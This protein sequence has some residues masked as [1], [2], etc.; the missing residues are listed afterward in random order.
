MKL[1]QDI[2]ACLWK[3]DTHTYLLPHPFLRPYIAHYTICHSHYMK[4]EQLHLVPDISGCIVMNMQADEGLDLKYWGPTTRM[5][6]VQREK[7]EDRVQYFVEF[8]P[9]GS[10]A[11][12]STAQYPYRDIRIELKQVNPRCHALI[13]EAYGKAEGEAAFF[14]QLDTIFLSMM[15]KEDDAMKSLMQGLSSNER[16]ADV[17]DSFGYSRR[18]LQ[19]LVQQRLGCSMKTIQK[20]QRI[21]QAVNL[22]KQQSLSLTAI[23]QQC[24]FYDQAHFIHDFREICNVTPQQYQKQLQDYYNEGFKF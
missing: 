4:T 2:Q 3:T 14:Q 7:G 15:S 12:F 18:H 17:M 20:I 10:H 13:T 21:N 24:G 23:A 5:V 22:L 8:R 6:T 11:L 19:R 9:S 1:K 16:I